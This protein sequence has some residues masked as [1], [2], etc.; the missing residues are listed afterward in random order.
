MQDFALL[1]TGIYKVSVSP[2][3]QSVFISQDA[4]TIL[5]QI[6]T[7]QFCIICKLTGIYSEPSFRSLKKMLTKIEPHIDTWG[8]MLFTDLQIHLAL[9]ISLFMTW[10]FICFSVHLIVF[11]SSL[12]IN[13]L[14]KTILWEIVLKAL[15]K[16]R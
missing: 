3:L 12:Y 10:P 8:I 7:P 15:L 13:I 11:S 9:W 5:W 4:S 6:I 14:S 16:F 2:L 1:L